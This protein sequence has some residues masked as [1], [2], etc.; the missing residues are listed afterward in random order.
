MNIVDWVLIGAILVF[1]WAG[2]RQGFV[3]GALSFAGFLGGGLLSAFWLPGF[4]EGAVSNS[5]LRIVLVGI[6]V[7]VSALAGQFLASLL[8]RSLRGRLSWKPVR[9]V[10]NIAGSALNILALAVVLWIIASAI[11]YLPDTPVSKEV[12]Q[13]KVLVALDG[14][15]PDAARNAFGDLRDLVGATAMP[16]VFSGFAEVIG[17]DVEPPDP[18]VLDLPGVAGARAGIVR[19]SGDAQECASTVNGSGFVYAPEY[20]MTN[21]HVVAGVQRPGVQPG[22]RDR[23]LRGRV[24]VFDPELDIA[25]LH[26]PGLLAPPLVFAPEPAESGSSAV[27]AGFPGLGGFRASPVRIR[28][29]VDAR[30]DDIYGTPGVLREVYAFRGLVQPGNSGGPLLDANGGVLG[31][32]FAAGQADSDT[33]FALT[34]EQVRAAAEA[35]LTKRQRVSSGSC[36]LG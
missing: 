8:G 27:A 12:R 10:D 28:T 11:A 30:G 34:A 13:S 29:T 5:T 35:G 26:V 18:E 2:W 33:G 25:V 22:L 19:V 9:F 17:P 7:L 1:A 4:I 32:V 21:A 36:V 16:R 3:A 20:V 14:A 31:M 15:V 6:G 23:P 24:V